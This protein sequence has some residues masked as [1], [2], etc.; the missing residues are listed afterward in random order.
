M[1]REERALELVEL[2]YRGALDPPS[3]NLLVEQLSLAFGGAAV[4]LSVQLPD[5]SPPLE[6]YTVGFRKEISELAERFLAEG[7]MP[8][9]SF[10]DDHFKGRF[11]FA[12][13]KFPDEELP[14]TDFYRDVMKPQGLAPEAPIIHLISNDA[15]RPLSGLAIHRREDGRPFCED[16]LRLGNLLAPHFARAFEMH[17]RFGGIQRER[18]A[19]TEVIDR[20]PL[21]VILI[22][23]R[24]QPVVTNRTAAQILARDDGFR[25]DQQG[26]RAADTRE[27]AALRKLVAEAVTVGSR[28]GGGAASVLSISR[29]SGQRS[30]PV[31]VAPLLGPPNG[32]TDRDAVA[33]L[34]LTDPEGNDISMTLVLQGLYSLTQAEAELVGLLAQG[35]SL[36]EA[37]RERGVTMNT[38]RSQLKQVFA[39]T[40]T[41][42]QGELV[43][44]VLSG[45]APIQ[46]D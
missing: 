12:S 40:D 22:D 26:P 23:P 15:G 44:L 31:M 41:K 34:F 38:V 17:S 10:L 27:D 5:S 29:P 25:F 4:A 30:Y 45:V 28:R 13:E 24:R 18:E 19:L 14:A 32:G 7:R 37:A 20:L 2:I 16:D 33:A 11:A 1:T 21:G 43:R 9:G 46:D 3:W 35:L 36:E 39:K 42:R 6:Y 8:W